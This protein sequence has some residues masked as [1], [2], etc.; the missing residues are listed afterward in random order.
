MSKISGVT[1]GCF[2]GADPELFFEQKGKIIGSEKVIPATW[3][4]DLRH[5]YSVDGL[6]RDGV[7]VELHPSP[8]TSPTQAVAAMSEVLLSLFKF[9]AETKPD[10]TPSFKGLVTVERDELNSLLPENRLL[11]CQPSRNIYKLRKAAVDGSKYLKRSAGGHVHFGL[12]HP[13]MGQADYRIRLPF[14]FDTV[15]GILGVLL[16]RDPDQV[17]RRKVYGQAGE[18]RLQKY[19]L[20]YRTPSNFWLRSPV[21]AQLVYGLGYLTVESLNLTLNNRFDYEKALLDK[22]DYKQVVKAIQ[23]NDVKLAREVWEGHVSPFIR[24]HVSWSYSLNGSHLPVF[25][26]FLDLVEIDGLDQF[27]PSDAA[28][29]SQ[30]WRTGQTLEKFLSA[31]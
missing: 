24:D 23:L 28:S 21:L 11:G 13:L 10:V 15:L 29:V 6:A 9:V 2:L 7:Q 27:F 17:E 20:E 22:V 4:S 3:S 8:M 5:K 16:D 1:I 25:T 26:K 30:A 19:G 12:S 14:M 31:V 18:F